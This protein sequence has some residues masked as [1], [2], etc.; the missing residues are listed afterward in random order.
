MSIIF[1]RFRAS[2]SN[3]VTSGRAVTAVTSQ[4]LDSFMLRRGGCYSRI[5][6]TTK[7]LR[8]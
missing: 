3:D 4:G 7:A 5:E 1:Q 6:I 8:Q 2:C